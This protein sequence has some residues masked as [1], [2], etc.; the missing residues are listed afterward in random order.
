MSIKY[1]II[2]DRYA[3]FEAQYQPWWW[4]FWIQC[5]GWNTNAT[6]EQAKRVIEIHKKVV[7]KRKKVVVYEEWL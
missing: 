4:P 6:I 2:T 5:N 7:G 1:R 3:G